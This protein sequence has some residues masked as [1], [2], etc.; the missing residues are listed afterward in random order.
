M[1]DREWLREMGEDVDEDELMEDE[2]DPGPTP[3]SSKKAKR[4]PTGAAAASAR[5]GRKSEG[6]KRGLVCSLSDP[7]S[8]LSPRDGLSEHWK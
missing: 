5:K 4:A 6:R 8:L 3:A 7:N 2:A 1:S